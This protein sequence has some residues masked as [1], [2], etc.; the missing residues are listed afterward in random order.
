[1][2]R[3]M[4]NH[5]RKGGPRSV[6]KFQPQLCLRLDLNKNCKRW[7]DVLL[8]TCAL[9][10]ITHQQPNHIRAPVKK[11]LFR[12]ASHCFVCV[13]LDTRPVNIWQNLRSTNGT[14]PSDL[15][16]FSLIFNTGHV[17]QWRVN[18]SAETLSQRKLTRD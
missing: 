1:M 13:F 18:L 16:I 5:V 14:C 6:K 12:Q 2:Q 7:H 17:W 11:L 10:S 9:K 15:K 4:L 8:D 3:L